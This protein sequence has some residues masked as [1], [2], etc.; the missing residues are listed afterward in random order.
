[1]S[2]IIVVPDGS[3][4]VGR[5]TFNDEVELHFYGIPWKCLYLVWKFITAIRLKKGVSRNWRLD[6]VAIFVVKKILKLWCYDGLINNEWIWLSLKVKYPYFS[7]RFSLTKRPQLLAKNKK[8]TKK[9][10]HLCCLLK[11]KMTYISKHKDKWYWVCIQQTTFKSFLWEDKLGI[12]RPYS[13][14]FG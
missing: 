1:M 7:C 2:Q 5:Q 4:L 13:W 12:R 9:K 3:L 8:N 14:W 10:F 11:S 6:F